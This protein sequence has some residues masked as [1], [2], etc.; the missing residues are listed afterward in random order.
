[1]RRNEHKFRN[2]GR[3]W[4]LPDRDLDLLASI[5]LLSRDPKNLQF[6]LNVF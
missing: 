5:D 4:R 1:M 2:T 6:T 3:G